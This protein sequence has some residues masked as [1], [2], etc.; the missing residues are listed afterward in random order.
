MGPR[1]HIVAYPTRSH[2]LD[3]RHDKRVSPGK[4]TTSARSATS[5]DLFFVMVDYPQG[6]QHH[7]VTARHGG[8]IR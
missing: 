6:L 8:V 1:H 4:A 5:Y 3:L 7:I 2:P